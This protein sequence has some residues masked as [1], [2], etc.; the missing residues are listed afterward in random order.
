MT[1]PKRNPFVRCKLAC[2][3]T[4]PVVSNTVPYYLELYSFPPRLGVAEG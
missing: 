4:S 1:W 2:A 3:P